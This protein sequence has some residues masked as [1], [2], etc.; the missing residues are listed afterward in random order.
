MSI[1]QYRTHTLTTSQTQT[2]THTLTTSQTH[3]HTHTHTQTDTHTQTHTHTHTHT[4]TRAHAQTHARL[5]YIAPL[6]TLSSQSIDTQSQTA[7]TMCLSRL[8]VLWNTQAMRPDRLSRSG[9]NV[10]G[11]W[12]QPPRGASNSLITSLP[13]FKMAQNLELRCVLLPAPIG[14]GKKIR[15]ESSIRQLTPVSFMIGF[16]AQVCNQRRRRHE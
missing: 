15:L 3:T 8:R 9:K 7:S 10:H 5:S 13:L 2:H 4:L 16:Q 12:H 1:L 14:A 11:R 6:C